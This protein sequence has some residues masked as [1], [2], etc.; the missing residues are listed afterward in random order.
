MFFA[1][2]SLKFVNCLCFS[3]V[4]TYSGEMDVALGVDVVMN[5]SGL[6]GGELSKIIHNHENHEGFDILLKY[7][8]FSIFAAK[9]Y[10]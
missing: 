2:I 9:S 1:R 3:L 8:C 7:L 5:K 10:G 6:S 4:L